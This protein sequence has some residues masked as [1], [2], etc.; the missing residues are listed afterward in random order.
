MK[1]PFSQFLISMVLLM[2]SP[3]N[4]AATLSPN[5]KFNFAYVLEGDADIAPGQVFDDGTK[6]FLQFNQQLNLPNF[7][8]DDGQGNPLITPITPEIQSPYIVISALTARLHL[9]RNQYHAVLV[10]Q[11]M[12][13][14][15]GLSSITQ[16]LGSLFSSKKMTQ[17]DQAKRPEPSRP[18]TMG[19]S[20]HAQSLLDQG[21]NTLI[22]QVHDREPLS[23]SIRIFLESQGW[24]LQWEHSDDFVIH[25]AYVTYGSSLPQLINS[26]LSEFHLK[27]KYIGNTV[28]VTAPES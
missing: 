20:L 6:I 8:L 13:Q 7:Y 9:N 23:Q 26:V 10:N 28:I 12:R 16:T 11:N 5:P 4:S 21:H 24:R 27:A 1:T 19:P 14:P 18:D 15:K 2:I 3:W 22:F 25:A 17:K